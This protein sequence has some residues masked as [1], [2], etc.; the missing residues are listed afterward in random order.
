MRSGLLSASAFGAAQWS[1]KELLYGPYAS[2]DG[3]ARCI[4][5]ISDRDVF[6]DHQSLRLELM[7]QHDRCLT[8][9]AE[10]FEDAWVNL[11][12]AAANRLRA[13]RGLDPIDIPPDDTD[14]A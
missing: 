11:S 13:M 2:D 14:K 10:T 3:L 1:A 9:A 6:A 4:R 12:V 7:S 5:R 8:E